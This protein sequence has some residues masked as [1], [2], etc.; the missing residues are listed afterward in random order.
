MRV[1][2]ESLRTISFFGSFFARPMHHL[3]YANRVMDLRPE[4]WDGL[5]FQSSSDLFHVIF[6]DFDSAKYAQVMV[7]Q[8]ML[9][10]CA[11]QSFLRV[12]GE[13][14]RLRPVK[15]VKNMVKQW[16]VVKLVRL[17]EAPDLRCWMMLGCETEET[18]AAQCACATE[19]QRVEVELYRFF[20][21]FGWPVW[22]MLHRGPIMNMV[23]RA[24]GGKVGPLAL[25]RR[26]KRSEFFQSKSNS[27]SFGEFFEWNELKWIEIA[28]KLCAT[29]PWKNGGRKENSMARHP[30]KVVAL[31]Q[32]NR[33]K[34][35]SYCDL[36]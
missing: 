6:I 33:L 20:F 12:N 18:W 1:P 25:I 2:S 13:T 27:K 16:N 32:S 5:Q 24:P 35:K 29:L 8:S 28:P 23:G 9:D 34:G 11:R 30:G 14:V 15:P 22:R 21:I 4:S 31:E 10:H 26:E 3:Y 19:N 17:L 36:Y 7:C